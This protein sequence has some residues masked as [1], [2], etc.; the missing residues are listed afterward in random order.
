MAVQ[1]HESDWQ[2]TQQSGQPGV[3]P[4]HEVHRPAA[5]PQPLSWRHPLVLTLVA[6]SIVAVLTLGV[7]GCTERKARLARE[8]MARV[9]AQTAHQMQLQAEQQ[10]REEIARQQARQAA[11]DQQ[12]AAKRQAAR[13]REQQEEAARRAEVAEAERKEQAWAKFYRKPASCNDAMTM[14]CTNDYIRAKR[15][16]ERKYAK[17]EL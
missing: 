9:N 12:E 13:E 5:Q 2:D 11:L 10:Q 17:G 8:E 16:F 3:A 7:R 6:L 14:A 4:T 15:D 1:D